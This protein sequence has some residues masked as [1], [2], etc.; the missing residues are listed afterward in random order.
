M[1]CLATELSPKGKLDVYTVIK[2]EVTQNSYPSLPVLIRSVLS[3]GLV[4]VVQCH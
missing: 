2:A 1:K 4:F 3:D